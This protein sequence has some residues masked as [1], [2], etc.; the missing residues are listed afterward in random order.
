MNHLLVSRHVV[1]D[2]SSFPFASSTTP[3]D[4]LD[5][6]LLSS[7]AVH[8][9]AP[10]DPSSIAGTLELDTVPCAALTPQPAP[11]ADPTPLSTPCAGS[12]SRF[13]EPPWCTSDD[14][15]PPHRSPL[16]PGRQ[17]TTPSSWLVTTT[18]PARWSPITL[19]GSPSMWIIYSSL[20]LSLVVPHIAVLHQ[21]CGTLSLVL[22][23]ICSVLADPH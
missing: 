6:L 8:L 2:E 11:R 16:T 4:D 18:T 21:A 22:T 3:P 15:C 17:S 9:I 13:T 7:P 19:S 23:P 1:F 12:A 14:I 10:P 5:S 20:P